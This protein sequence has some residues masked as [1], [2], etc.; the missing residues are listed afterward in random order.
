M[1]NSTQNYLL[2]NTPLSTICFS[3]TTD[4]SSIY[5]NGPGGIAGDGLPLPRRGFL[6]GFTLW[7]GSLVRSDADKVSFNSGDRLSVYCQNT[8]TD[9]T[10]KVRLNGVST[11]LQITAVPYNS[12]LQAVV[13]FMLVRE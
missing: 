4:T 11:S 2:A 7:D 1:P 13:E 8:G 9:S 3:G 12:T 10:V 6:T 5:L